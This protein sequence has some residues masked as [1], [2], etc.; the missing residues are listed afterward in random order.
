MNPISTRKKC[1]NLLKF[2]DNVETLLGFW[3]FYF[4]K[5]PVCLFL[6]STGCCHSILHPEH[7][8][9]LGCDK[10]KWN[11]WINGTRQR[12][13]AE[14]LS[15]I[16]QFT[17]A[18]HKAEFRRTLYWVFFFTLDFAYLFVLFCSFELKFSTKYRNPFCIKKCM[19][20][21]ESNTNFKRLSNPVKVVYICLRTFNFNLDTSNRKIQYISLI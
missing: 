6:M 21:T 11:P 19:E 1:V 13:A 7:S 18:L 15:G 2:S 5:K 12:K 20:Q 9:A 10:I 17:R 4:N 8:T 16:K 3:C 14:D